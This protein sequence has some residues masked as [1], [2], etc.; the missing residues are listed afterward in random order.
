MKR[1][2]SVPLPARAVEI[3]PRHWRSGETLPPLTLS[4]PRRGGWTLDRAAKAARAYA[5]ENG[6]GESAAR[7]AF[8]A[9][10]VYAHPRPSSMPP[11]A[12]YVPPLALAAMRAR[13]RDGRDP[14]ALD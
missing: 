3:S 9:I 4:P 14:L 2:R 1:V 7:S 13:L 5:H 10:A 6:L 11:D 12:H 8:R